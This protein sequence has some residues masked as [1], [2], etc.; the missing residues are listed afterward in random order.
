MSASSEPPVDAYD[1]LLDRLARVRGALAQLET[2]NESETAQGAESS[3][4]SAE[5]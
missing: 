2:T 4:A 5:R 1:V 3:E